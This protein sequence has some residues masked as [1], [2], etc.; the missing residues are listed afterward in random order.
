MIE[1]LHYL[2][3]NI[4][5]F[6]FYKIEKISGCY[7]L[8]RTLILQRDLRIKRGGSIKYRLHIL[9]NE[10]RLHQNTIPQ[11][12]VLHPDFC[13]R[14]KGAAQALKQT[15]CHGSNLGMRG[16]SRSRRNNLFIG[17]EWNPTPG[18]HAGAGPLHNPLAQPKQTGSVGK[19]VHLPQGLMAFITHLQRRRFGGPQTVRTL[20]TNKQNCSS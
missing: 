7:H 9:G 1:C 12:L 20:L 6:E 3:L 10:K 8:R 14:I 11:L 19:I 16:K 5:S 17:S 2:P 4:G 13:C 15:S 18:F